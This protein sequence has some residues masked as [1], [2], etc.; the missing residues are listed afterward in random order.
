MSTE[1]HQLSEKIR[2]ISE[3]L[4]EKIVQKLRDAGF[5]NKIKQKDGLSDV[6]QT[7][8]NMT[9]GDG[10]SVGSGTV[11]ASDGMVVTLGQSRTDQPNPL[12]T[13]PPMNSNK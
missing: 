12:S 1:N 3:E 8:P 5:F 7:L 10:P 9:S 6:V 11:V 2:K 4:A 13:K